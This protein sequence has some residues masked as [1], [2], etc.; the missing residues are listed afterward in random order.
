V[1]DRKIILSPVKIRPVDA[2]LEDIRNK[3]ERLGIS[4]SDVKDAVTWARKRNKSKNC[5]R[6]HVIISAMIFKG[7]VSKIVN[8]WRNGTIIPLFSKGTFGEFK[9]VLTYPKLPCPRRN[10]SP[11]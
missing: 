4:D 6:Y 5:P 11:H 8:L 9:T 7:E 10:R 1:K 3:M 2:T